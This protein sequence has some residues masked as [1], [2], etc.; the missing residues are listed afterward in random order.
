[1]PKEKTEAQVLCAIGGET[2]QNN[3]VMKNQTTKVKDFIFSSPE[4]IKGLTPMRTAVNKYGVTMCYYLI[5]NHNKEILRKNSFLKDFKDN[6][7]E[8][9]IWFLNRWAVNIVNNGYL[10]NK[11][12]AK[13]KSEILNPETWTT[14]T[15]T[16]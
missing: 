2:T 13:E 15:V 6:K 7:E 1:M 14:K 9:F 16:K 11:F 5:N 3:K 8:D 4:K 10:M 12:L